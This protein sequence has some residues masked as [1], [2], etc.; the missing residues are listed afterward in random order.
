LR[1]LSA[2]HLTG[3]VTGA[4]KQLG[5]TQPA[6][7]LQLRAL[8]NI[9]GLP[10][11]RR[12][13]DCTA[14]TDAGRELVALHQ[15]ISA[16]IGDSAAMIDA[17]KGLAGG[18][19][20]VGAVSTAKYF[21]P[22]AIAGFSKRFPKIGINLSI[23]NRKEI[24]AALRD[25]T[26]DLAITGRPPEDMDLERRLIGDHPHMVIAPP[27]H[28]LGRRRKLA[29]SDLAEETF[30]VREPDSGTRLLIQRAFSEHRFEPRI[31]M[32]IDSN[33]TIKQAVMAGLGVTFVSG[34]TVA[35]ELS[36]G[37]LIALDIQGMPI[38]RQ[39]YVVWRKERPLLP[40]AMALSEYFS[41]SFSRFLPKVFGRKSR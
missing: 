6:V 7:T 15:R 31:G 20:A 5:L 32:E 12:A 25:Y 4:A 38:V 27:D 40:P 9:V 16:A 19:V 2:I 8:Q 33:E 24:L 11:I 37:R 22:F 35:T 18:V 39:W 29:L 3:S 1:A 26:L 36:D 23:G 17:I 30:L 10:L 34:H 14:L 13:N 41:S 28:P 21:V